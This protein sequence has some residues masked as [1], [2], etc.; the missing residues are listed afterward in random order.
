MLSIHACPRL[1]AMSSYRVA[2][3]EVE[4]LSHLLSVA[5]ALATENMPL[6]VSFHI[7]ERMSVILWAVERDH[8]RLHLSLKERP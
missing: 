7:L 4:W 1:K 3:P 5:S 2:L 8:S 6:R